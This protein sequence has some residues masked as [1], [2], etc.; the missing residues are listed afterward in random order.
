MSTSGAGPILPNL[1]IGGAQKSG[2]TTLHRLLITHPQ[3][4]FPASPREIHFFD[5]DENFARGLG[6]YAHLFRD[7]NGQPVIGQTSPLYLYDERVPQ[8]ILEALGSD[9]RFVFILRNPADRAYSHYWH[10]VKYGH[11]SLPF[12]EALAREPER[13]QRG[14][15]ERRRYS[16]LDRGRYAGQLERFYA[17]FPRANVLVLLY[18]ELRRLDD[19]SRKCAEFLDLSPRE[20]RPGE[21]PRG[22]HYNPSRMPRIRGLQ[23]LTAPLRRRGG[24]WATAARL[25]DLVNLREARYPPLAAEARARI[26]VAMKEEI[27][28]LEALTGADLSSWRT[29]PPAAAGGG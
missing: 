15:W 10:E 1:I 12:P 22:F 4:F 7:W 9:V 18:E 3:V 29:A 2:T 19:V 24:R 28:R 8:R 6:W 11:E 14:Y 16:Y 20:W 17:R 21:D 13:I 26:A 5:H 23:R 25:V 27:A